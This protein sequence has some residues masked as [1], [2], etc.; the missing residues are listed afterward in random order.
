MNIRFKKNSIL[1]L[2]VFMLMI[3]PGC[4]TRNHFRGMEPSIKPLKSPSYKII[5]EAET[6]VSNFNLLWF[7]AVTSLPDYDKAILETVKEKGGDDL[8]DVRWWHERQ[9]WILGTINIIHIKGKVIKYIS[10]DD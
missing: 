1:P 5:D 10:E 6:K 7:F 2:L 9:D 3:V 4:I 8:I